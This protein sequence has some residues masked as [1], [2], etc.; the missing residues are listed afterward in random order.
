MIQKIEIIGLSAVDFQ[1]ILDET[2]EKAIEKAQKVALEQEKA[3]S[4][5]EELTLEKACEELGCCKRTLRRRMKA[6]KINGYRFGREIRLQRKDL[7]K[8]RQAQ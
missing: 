3:P 7:K 2:V 5:W 1:R 4:E 6:L 8:I